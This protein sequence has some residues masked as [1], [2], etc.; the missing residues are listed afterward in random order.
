MLIYAIFKN[1]LSK[2]FI[3]Q[4]INLALNQFTNI[5]NVNDRMNIKIKVVPRKI[6][7]SENS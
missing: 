7:F 6:I 2:S 5:L 4:K 1:S 3:K